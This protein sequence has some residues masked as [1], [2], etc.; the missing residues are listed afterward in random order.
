MILSL[1]WGVVLRL[2]SDALSVF[3]FSSLSW[4]EFGCGVGGLR[5]E[6]VVLL[7]CSCSLVVLSVVLVF[8]GRK[9]LLLEREQKA[10]FL[11][12]YPNL[13]FE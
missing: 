13:S 10:S 6:V 1:G 5:Y 9:G 8:D 12:K 7:F 3:C 4:C 2:F 11:I